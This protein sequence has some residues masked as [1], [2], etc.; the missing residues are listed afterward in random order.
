[1]TDRELAEQIGTF[2]ALETA[3]RAAVAA[4]VDDTDEQNAARTALRQT[5]AARL[6][7]ERWM[8]LR[9]TRAALQE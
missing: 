1:M 6:G 3:Q 9:A 7:V 5:V 8:L 2:G 4:S